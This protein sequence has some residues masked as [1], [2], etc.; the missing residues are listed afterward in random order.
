MGME[1]LQHLECYLLGCSIKRWSPT[2]GNPGV[3]RLQLPQIWQAQLGAAV[4]EHLGYS[5]LRT[6]VLYDPHSFKSVDSQ[7][8]LSGSIMKAVLTRLIPLSMFNV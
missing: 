6:M 8:A 2:V 5:T 1:V 3:H 7:S 4:Q